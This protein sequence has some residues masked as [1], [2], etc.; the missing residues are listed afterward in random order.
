[1]ARGM[2]TAS[3]QSA[4]LRGIPDGACAMSA[5]QGKQQR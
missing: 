1:M 3:Q 4:C 5:G 2:S